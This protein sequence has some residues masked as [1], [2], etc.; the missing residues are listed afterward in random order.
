MTSR[1]SSTPRPA[2][3]KEPR[4]QP[5]S[6]TPAGEEPVGR[7]AWEPKG[8]KDLEP[9]PTWKG[10]RAGVHV[11]SDWPTKQGSY[12]AGSGTER[13]GNV[14]LLGTGS[15]EGENDRGAG[16]AVR[17]GTREGTGNVTAPGT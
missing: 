6:T 14:E 17:M 16:N 9:A 5:R 12:R 8:R 4:R 3:E 10:P 13:H 11:D 2:A 7:K 1:P 15:R